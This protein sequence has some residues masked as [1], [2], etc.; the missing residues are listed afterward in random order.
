MSPFLSVS[1]LA[2]AGLCVSACGGVGGK[3]TDDGVYFD[4]A[5][6]LCDPTASAFDDLFLFE[7]WTGGDAVAVE[8][9]VLDGGDSLDE[10]ALEEDD[11]GYWSREEW[12]DDLGTDCDEFS[13]LRFVFTARGSDGSEAEAEAAG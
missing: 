9:E 5:T 11:D 1:R 10:L 13:Y 2:L 7:A 3:S 4:D 8:V 12:A 6:V